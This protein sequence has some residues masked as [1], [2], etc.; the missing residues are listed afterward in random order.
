MCK[1]RSEAAERVRRPERKARVEDGGRSP[2]PGLRAIRQDRENKLRLTA[3]KKANLRPGLRTT[4]RLPHTAYRGS[5]ISFAMKRTYSEMSYLLGFAGGGEFDLK[6]RQPSKVPFKVG[7]NNRAIAAACRQPLDHDDVFW[8]LIHQAGGSADRTGEQTFEWLIGL[9]EDV[10]L[11][12]LRMIDEF[13]EF[14]HESLLRQV[15]GIV[16]Y[17]LVGRFTDGLLVLPRMALAVCS[18]PADVRK[19]LSWEE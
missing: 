1:R 13:G 8:R 18:S 10:V 4:V 16:E 2:R 3:S 14:D 11:V 7:P 5:S 15:Q 19:S 17:K 12:Q 6:R 9:R